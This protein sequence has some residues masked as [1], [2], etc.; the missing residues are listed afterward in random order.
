M[1]ET[2]RATANTILAIPIL[3][4]QPHRSQAAHAEAEASRRQEVQA[5]SGRK[6]EHIKQLMAQHEQVRALPNI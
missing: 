2:Q 1:Y 6:D 5:L 4:S 3:L